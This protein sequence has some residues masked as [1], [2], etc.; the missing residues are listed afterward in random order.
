M[1]EVKI[2]L[3]R[4][5]PVILIIEDS[6]LIVESIRSTIEQDHQLIFATNSKSGLEMALDLLPDLIL[7]DMMNP[8]MDGFKVWSIL[9]GNDKTSTIPI[10]LII[11]Q[12]DKDDQRIY[13]ASTDGFIIWPIHPGILKT[14][15]RSH[16]EL[17]R[18]RDLLGK[19][20]KVDSL[21][22]LPNRQR[23]DDIIELEWKR[24][25]RYQ[26]S[27]INDPDGYRLLQSI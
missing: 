20:I 21:T 13:Q 5:Q 3:D 12:M 27:P 19:L 1:D 9:K 8:G 14:I 23:L 24:A 22:G 16:L 15:V 6:T 7:M 18:S 2:K 11:D 25:I 17:K 10:L 26:N 4:K